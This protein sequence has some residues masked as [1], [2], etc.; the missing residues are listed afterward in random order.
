MKLRVKKT[1]V[2]R[3]KVPPYPYEPYA[4]QY[5]D[6]Y[7]QRPRRIKKAK[8]PKEKKFVEK[9]SLSSILLKLLITVSI[10]FCVIFYAWCVWAGETPVVQCSVCGKDVTSYFEVSVHGH[11]DYG[12]GSVALD[13]TVAALSGGIKPAVRRNICEECYGQYMEFFRRN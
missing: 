2:E 1:T 4:W 5:A 9:H 3:W 6:S 12:S 13:T 7:A 11:R 8:I 10:V